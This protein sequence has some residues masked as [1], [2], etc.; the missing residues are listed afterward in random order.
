MA[1]TDASRAAPRGGLTAPAVVLVEPQLGENIGMAARAMLNGGLTDLRLVKPRARWPSRKAVAASSGADRVVTGARLF[2]TTADA[3]ADLERVYAA[4]A[5]RRGMTVRVLTPRAAAA[6]MRALAAKGVRTG[7][8]FGKEAKGLANDDIVLADAVITAP[9]NP[10]YSSLNLAQA[11][12]VMAYEWFAAGDATPAA[13]VTIPPRTR[14]ATKE[15][16][17]GFFQHLEDELDACGF[18]QIAHK[19]PVMV[20]NLRN[21]FERAGLTEQEV[22]TLRGVVACL[23]GRPA[24]RPKP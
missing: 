21:A 8:L 4:T 2:A 11:V 5:R 16:L 13:T 10:S 20:R 24:R 12:L 23:A 7:I 18:L 17:L 19:R 6:E 1:G 22:R 9:L 15:E 14:P 3:I